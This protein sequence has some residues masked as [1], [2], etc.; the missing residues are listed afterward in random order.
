MSAYIKLYLYTAPV[1]FAIDI[2]WLGVVAANFYQERLGHLLADEVFWPA[3]LVFYALYIAGI[4][5]FAVIPGLQSRSLR[6][7]LLHA[8]GFGFFTYLTYELTNMAT[9]PNWPISVV[10]VDTLWGMV[11]CSA[12]AAIAYGIGRFANLLA[13]S[14]T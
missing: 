13:P 4:L 12:V 3:A 5:S 7:T 11:L 1:F 8:L 2:L 6:K 10:L 9:L 14:G